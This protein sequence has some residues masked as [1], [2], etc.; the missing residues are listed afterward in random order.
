M[1]A[2]ERTVETRLLALLAIVNDWLKYAE[3]KNSLIVGLA[4]AG[5][6]GSLATLPKAIESSTYYGAAISLLVAGEAAL[7]TSVSISLTSFLPKTDLEAWVARRVGQTQ[8]SDNLYYYGHLAKY[9]PEQLAQ[10]FARRYAS[11]ERGDAP[12]ESAVDVAA[13]IISN[14]RITL[15]KLRLFVPALLAFVAGVFLLTLS[16]LIGLT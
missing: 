14:A 15:W 3:T 11:A 7:A 8:S 5:L 10:T 2:D 9:A 12:S 6:L 13:Q 1:T 16:A 4:S